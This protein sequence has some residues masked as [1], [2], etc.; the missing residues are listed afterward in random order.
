VRSEAIFIGGRSSVGKTTVAF[1]VHAQLSAADV[2]HC[3]IDGDFLDMAHPPP[4]E[5]KLAERYL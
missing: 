1:E 4:W 3:L 2:P 5:H